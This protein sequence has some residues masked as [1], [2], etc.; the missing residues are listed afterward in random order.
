MTYA[1]PT[2][3]ILHDKQAVIF[4]IDGTLV[5][6]CATHLRAWQQVLAEAGVEAARDRL[7]RLFGRHS[8]EWVKQLLPPERQNEG[9]RIVRR[10]NEIFSGHLAD[11]RP[12]PRARELLVCV[13]AAG[14]RLAFATGATKEELEH[15]LRLLGAEEL[16]DAT[17]YDREVARGKPAPDIYALAATRLGVE[18][19]DAVAVG[20]GLYDVMSARGAGMACVALLT[21]GFSA[22]ELL[23]SGAAEVYPAVADLH[24]AFCAQSGRAVS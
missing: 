12:F 21:G 23:A 24:N 22:R 19:C 2:L 10:K 17:A 18:P 9:A 13:K 5:D 11:L 16:A 20:D 4:D 3:T 1:S 7:E 14:K 15:H 8:D 6:S